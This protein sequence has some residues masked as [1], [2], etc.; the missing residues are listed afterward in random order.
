[1]HFLGLVETF[2]VKKLDEER[3]SLIDEANQLKRI[4]STILKNIVEKEKQQAKGSQE[5]GN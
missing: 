5:S 1:M 3:F 4:F 2:D